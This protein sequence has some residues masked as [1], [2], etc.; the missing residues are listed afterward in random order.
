MSFPSYRNCLATK[1]KKKSMFSSRK[2]T[3][4]E[5][6]AIIE[7]INVNDRPTQVGKARTAFPGTE[8]HE[9]L[10]SELIDYEI[11]QRQRRRV[12]KENARIA[13]Q[14][15]A[16]KAKQEQNARMINNLNNNSKALAQEIK[17]LEAESRYWQKYTV[18]NCTREL[19]TRYKNCLASMINSGKM[20][21][22]L[23]DN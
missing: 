13:K 9:R 22:N 19:S 1:A 18:N 10:Q 3:P 2:Y 8:C 7:E 17:A 6:D 11:E 5:I 23:Y 16:K 12:E 4:E 14:L 20:N 21:K 15:A